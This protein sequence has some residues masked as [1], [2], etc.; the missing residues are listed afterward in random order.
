MRRKIA[1]LWL[2][3]ALLTA[4]GIPSAR[5]DSP[6][7]L[8]ANAAILP[9]T[10]SLQVVFKEVG[11]GLTAVN[12]NVT[13][14]VSQATATYQCFNNGGK[15]PNSDNKTLQTSLLI[16][17]TFPVSNGET[18]GRF[19]TGPVRPGTFSCSNGQSLYLV[20]VSYSFMRVI[21]SAGDSLPIRPDPVSMQL[22]IPVG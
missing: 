1:A 3:A 15:S 14:H 6:Q 11:L 5:A 22:M 17:Q 12:E 16:T 10:G 9:N 13:L 4:L 21:G 2:L 18:T 7:F 20:F 19:V 8:Y